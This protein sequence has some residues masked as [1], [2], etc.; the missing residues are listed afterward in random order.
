MFTMNFFFVLKF[1]FDLY[2]LKFAILHNCEYTYVQ[3]NLQLSVIDYFFS[4][5]HELI[6]VENDTRIKSL[7]NRE[8]FYITGAGDKWSMFFPCFVIFFSLCRIQFYI[9]IE[10]WAKTSIIFKTWTKQNRHKNDAYLHN[11]LKD[12]NALQL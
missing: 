12:T 4:G 8:Y 7:T 2:C 10:I 6:L 3:C 1:R 9:I 11:I 5:F